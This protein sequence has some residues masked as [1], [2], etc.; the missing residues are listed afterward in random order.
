VLPVATGGEGSGRADATACVSGWPASRSNG[1][2]EASGQHMLE[3]AAQEPLR[4]EG[5][6]ALLAAMRV[7]LPAEGD[8]GVGDREQ[9]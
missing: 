7:V 6:G 4:G 3:E 1:C 5:H 2:A 8:L 9:N